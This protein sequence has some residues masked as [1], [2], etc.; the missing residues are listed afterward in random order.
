M[1]AAIVIVLSVVSFILMCAEPTD[2]TDFAT[3]I[4]VKAV[5]ILC[6]YAAYRVAKSWHGA[7]EKF[8]RFVDRVIA[9]E[10]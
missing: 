5:G 4:G 3:L 9:E 8:R 1:K 10:D 7:S 2:A 6:A